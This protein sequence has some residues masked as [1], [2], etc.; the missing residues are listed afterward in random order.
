MKRE[1]GAFAI[2]SGLYLAQLPAV[3]QDLECKPS[4]KPS[5]DLGREQRLQACA[6]VG[7]WDAVVAENRRSGYRPEVVSWLDDTVSAMR[8]VLRDL[9]KL[10][11][12]Q[13]APDTLAQATQAMA[14]QLAGARLEDVKA[15]RQLASQRLNAE[16]IAWKYLQPVYVE[17]FN[18]PTTDPAT[19]RSFVN[20][21]WLLP[22]GDDWSATVADGAYTL[23][24]RASPKAVHYLHFRVRCDD[25]INH[26][27]SV[28]VRLD[29]RA[30][31]GIGDAGLLY[32]FDPNT[33]RYYMFTL[34]RGG[35]LAFSKRNQAG[36][37]TLYAEAL[38]SLDA[39]RL[40]RLAI[41]GTDAAMFLYVNNSLVK[42]IEDSELRGPSSGVVAIGIGRFTFDNFTIY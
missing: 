15:S 18:V 23:E 36:F 31:N 7:V 32:R 41:V 16:N 21:A 2:C 17:S 22:P 19:V 9:D 5:F 29:D 34:G 6:L 24:N 37:R 35:R 20:P 38:K 28:E 25:S 4:A 33:H 39:T 13:L 8:A 42:V 11:C 3:A 26:P 10:G 12:G 40:N 14:S 1:L 30:D 27:A